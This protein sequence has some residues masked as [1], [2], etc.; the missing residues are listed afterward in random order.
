MAESSTGVK[1]FVKDAALAAVATAALDLF[2][3]ATQL[4]FLNDRSPIPLGLDHEQVVMETILTGSG[5][6]LA[7]LG[8]LSVFAG[9]SI[10]PGFGHTALAYGAGILAGTSFYEHQLVKPL[11]IRNIRHGVYR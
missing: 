9:K 7:T 1:G 5:L 2:V 10:I 11:G 3:E 6:V 8:G 4:P